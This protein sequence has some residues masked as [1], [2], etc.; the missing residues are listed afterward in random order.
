MLNDVIEMA[1]PEEDELVL[2]LIVGQEDIV[3]HVPVHHGLF[4]ETRGVNLVKVMDERQN[5]GVLTLLVQGG[6]S[7]KVAETPAGIRAHLK[8]E[9]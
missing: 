4:T 9:L 8:G 5:E 1:G 2:G 3:L 6:S 7:R